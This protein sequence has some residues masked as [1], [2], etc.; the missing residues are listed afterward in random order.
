M[1]RQENSVDRGVFGRNG[2]TVPL[3]GCRLL[4]HLHGRVGEWLLTQRFRNVEK[5]P[6]EATYL[7]PLPEE[8]AVCGF[9]VRTGDRLLRGTVEERDNAFDTY[10][11]AMSEG[12]GAFLLDQERPNVFQISVGNLLPGQEVQVELRFIQLAA[13]EPLGVRVMIPTTISPRYTPAHLSAEAKAEIERITPPYAD[14]VPYGLSLELE[15]VMA[16]PVKIVESPSHPLRTEIDGCTA[17]IR[18]GQQTSSLDHDLVILIETAQAHAM[19]AIATERNGREHLLIECIP[20][21][22]MASVQERKTVVFLL[23]CSGSM[24]GDSIAQARQAVE[25]CLRALQPGDRFQIVRFGSDCRPLTPHPVEFSQASLDAAVGQIRGIEADLGGTEILKA[26]RQIESMIATDQVNLLI[27][28]D[29]EVSNE[30]EVLAWAGAL[31]HRCRAFS[32]GIGAGSSEYLVRGIARRSGGAAEF[33]YPGERIE[34]KVL[35]QFA[36]VATSVATDLQIDWGVPGAEPAP[37]QIPAVFAGESLLVAARFPA[38]QKPA[39]GAMVTVRGKTKT[40]EL[41]WK[42]EIRRSKLPT[43]EVAALWWARQAILELE[44][45]RG[46]RQNGS[47]Q[48]RGGQDAWQKTLVDLSCEYGI[49]CGSTSFVAIEERAAGQKSQGP[50]EL[51][52]V[53]VQ[54]TTGWH[55]RPGI[56]NAG[57]GV[58]CASMAAPDYRFFSQVACT[59][60]ESIDAVSMAQPRKKARKA[61]PALRETLS[62][63]LSSR[64]SAGERQENSISIHILMLQQAEGWFLLNEALAGIAG[65]SLPELRGWARELSVAAGDDPEKLLATILAMYLLRTRASGEEDLWR[66]GVRKAETLLAG[67]RFSGPGGDDA[68]AWLAGKL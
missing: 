67:R 31:K 65:H 1:I 21:G 4:G 26:L 36:R 11:Q 45:T 39:E 15:A 44:E 3:I 59:C 10:D 42:A 55:G 13:P 9:S 37:R 16:S 12:D 33:I 24:Q 35:R 17:R 53:P 5:N 25:L 43:D 38:G 58:V 63:A 32:F 19:S 40:G 30:D 52:R 27:M 56:L 2:E 60:C 20:D 57:A 28:T 7:F 62:D 66:A 48:K 6:I 41:V 50:A 49:L 46:E 54:V 29:G 68:F 23:D 22:Q 51:R 18:F 47:Q 61:W 14:A 8:A 64:T 34:P